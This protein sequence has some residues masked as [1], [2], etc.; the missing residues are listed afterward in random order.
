M[1]K[2]PKEPRYYACRGRVQHRMTKGGSKRCD[3]P[4]IRA[5]WLEW[6]VWNK[7]KAVLNNSDELVE[8]V[9][10]ALIE[11]EERKSQ[12]G[13]ETLTIGSKLEAIRAK[14]E[15]LGMAFADAAV[16]ES[17]YKSKLNQLKKQEAAILKC[18]YDIDPRELT[19]LAVV[20]GR[21]AMVKD[22]LSQGRLSVSEF[23]IFGKKGNE[24]IPAGFNA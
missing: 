11:L 19:D 15:R 5:D 18:R 4:Y 14:K 7:I 16:S 22:V 17:A 3:L 6:G 10:K 21:I 9:N 20:E 12:I 13:T 2:K 8:C 23:G 24:Y 1:R